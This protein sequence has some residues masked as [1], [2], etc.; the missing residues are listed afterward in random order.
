MK[1]KRE[2][3]PVRIDDTKRELQ[4]KLYIKHKKEKRV[5]TKI[6]EQIN[7]LGNEYHKLHTTFHPFPC[8]NTPQFLEFYVFVCVV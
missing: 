8:C 6:R 1:F 5:K 3:K 2:S 4:N 7:I